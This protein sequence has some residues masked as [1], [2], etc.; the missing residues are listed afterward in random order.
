VK[1]N[2]LNFMPPILK[3]YSPTPLLLKSGENIFDAELDLRTITTEECKV[4]VE[5]KVNEEVYQTSFVIPT[6]GAI[7][8]TFDEW[9]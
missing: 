8:E 9:E 7:K 1:V 3:I 4:F 6:A 5:Y 2:T